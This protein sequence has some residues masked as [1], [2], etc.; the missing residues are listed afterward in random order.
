MTAWPRLS[1]SRP[2][3]ARQLIQRPTSGINSRVKGLVNA[4][5]EQSDGLGGR[6]SDPITEIRHARCPQYQVHAPL[7]I[8]TIGRAE[9]PDHAM[10]MP[11]PRA[12]IRM[13]SIEY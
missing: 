5:A 6:C 13:H 12:I 4:V 2:C 9:R 3:D 10:E 8:T 11:Y 1:T 7:P